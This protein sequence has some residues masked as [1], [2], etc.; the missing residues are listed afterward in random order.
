MSLLYLQREEK[1]T[2]MEGGSHC[3]FIKEGGGAE[4]NNDNGKEWALG[5]LL[6]YI[7]STT[8]DQDY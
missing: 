6:F 1:T 8:N 3:L 4:H 2:E 7:P 5:I